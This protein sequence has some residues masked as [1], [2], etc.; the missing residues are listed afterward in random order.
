MGATRKITY[1]SV[2]NPAGA[3]T[4]YSS[5]ETK[6]E[7]FTEHSELELLSKG[8]KA[9]VRNS[10]DPSDKGYGLQHDGQKLP[11]GDFVLYFLVDKNDSG[12]K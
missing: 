8:M 2:A 12:N 9:W 4:I 11:E 10:S 5:A 7:L 1:S 6:G 3:S